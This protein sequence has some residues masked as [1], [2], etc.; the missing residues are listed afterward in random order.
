[1]SKDKK[2]SFTSEQIINAAEMQRNWRKAVEPKLKEQPFLLMFSGSEP[3]ASLISYDKFEELWMKAQELSELKLKMEL[4]YR[5]LLNKDKEQLIPL[6]TV[7]ED[8]SISWADLEEDP[9]V[10]LEDE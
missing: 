2:P 4:V 3:K 10:E 9:D 6:K 5:M 7:L 8:N 1:M